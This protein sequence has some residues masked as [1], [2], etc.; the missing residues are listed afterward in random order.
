[1]C[2]VS[3]NVC[4]VVPFFAPVAPVRSKH[5]MTASVSEGA[6]EGASCITAVAFGDSPGCVHCSGVGMGWSKLG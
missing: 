4:V 5:E 6:D 2:A 1:M 3:L